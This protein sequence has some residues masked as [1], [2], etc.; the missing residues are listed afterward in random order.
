MKIAVMQPYI[1]PY[2]GYFQL[3][4]SADSFILYDDVNFI[5]QGWVNRNRIL[6][7]GKE[8]LFTIPLKNASSFTPIN[9]TELHPSL[10]AKW[11]IKFLRTLVQNYSKAP[12]FNKTYP[13]IEN[14]FKEDN[15]IS[16]LAT[17][18]ILAVLDYL[19]LKTKIHI[20]SQDFKES[21]GLD[22]ADRLIEISK[23]LNGS[24]Y[25]NMIGGKD[26]YN[27]EYFKKQNVELLF[28]K[29]RI[30][31]YEQLGHNFIPA[32]SIIDVLMFNDKETI[33][34]FL[35]DYDFV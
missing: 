8:N 21:K 11:R 27:R 5:K 28:L 4:N 3:I 20:S 17:N 14:V 18:S 25:V 16:V 35:T 6:A 23:K 12:Y 24:T 31:E 1:F 34:S 19:D 13:V 26:L 7:N 15:N 10:Y 32:L 33:L 9:E 2:L 30:K 22:R 29:P